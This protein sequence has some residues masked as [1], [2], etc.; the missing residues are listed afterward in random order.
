MNTK[1]YKRSFHDG[2]RIV[3]KVH[4][5]MEKLIA[6]NEIWGVPRKDG[7]LRGPPV[8]EITELEYREIHRLNKGEE[9]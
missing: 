6:V 1:Y 3:T 4:T 9:E 5:D 8:T 2:G 7:V